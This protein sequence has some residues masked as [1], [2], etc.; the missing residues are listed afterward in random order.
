MWQNI[1]IKQ[2]ELVQCNLLM[3]KGGNFPNVHTYKV[4]KEASF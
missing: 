4:S 2:S 3:W 1:L